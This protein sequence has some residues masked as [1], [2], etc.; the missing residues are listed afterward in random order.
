MPPDSADR[1]LTAPIRAVRSSKRH[2]YLVSCQESV[3]RLL[4]PHRP[5]GPLGLPRSLGLLKSSG[6]L[7]LLGPLRPLGQSGQSE[8]LKQLRQLK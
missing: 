6:S 5:H 2:L 8:Q 1:F 3:R 4:G 7:G